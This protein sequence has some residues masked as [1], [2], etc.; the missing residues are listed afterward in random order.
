MI[1]VSDAIPIHSLPK[2]PSQVPALKIFRFKNSIEINRELA[3]PLPITPLPTDTPHR[4]TYYEI[5]FVEEGQGFHEIDFHSYAVQGAGVHFLTPGQVH[6]LTFSSSFQG[7]IVAFSEDF[8]TFYNPVGQPLSQL[9][10]FQPARRQPI[11][12][13]SETE[14]RYFHNILENMVSDHLN[15]D[16][17]QALIGKYLGVFLQK[18][19]LLSQRNVQPEDAGTQTLP[20]LVGRF[21]ELVEKNF[22][23]MHE[24]QQYANALSVSP[25]Y[26]SKITKKYLGTPSQEYILDKLLLEAKRLLVFTSLS[27][28]EIAYHI[29]LDDPSYFSR[30]FKKKT[31]LTPNEY[32]DQV[33]KSTIH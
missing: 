28:K 17:D 9:P 29:H 23:Q 6:L 19:A 21:Q 7:F 20:E 22:R 4:H 5:L 12:T 14:K 27:S 33:R 32:R 26:L 25:D 2:T 30:I 10:F 16:A 3:I 24:V 8:Y 31:G 11:I 13:L 15:E 18:C 1:P